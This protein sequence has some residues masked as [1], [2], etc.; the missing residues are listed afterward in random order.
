MASDISNIVVEN[1]LTDFDLHDDEKALFNTN[2]TKAENSKSIYYNYYQLNDLKEILS[3]TQVEI[4]LD[5][6]NA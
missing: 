6:E 5:H 1:E 4:V 3:S 2:V